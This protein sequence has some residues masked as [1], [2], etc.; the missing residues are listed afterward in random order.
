L[1]SEVCLNRIGIGSC[2]AYI[3]MYDSTI[4]GIIWQKHVHAEASGV[5]VTLLASLNLV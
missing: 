4:A 2:V 1:F 5:S 3:V